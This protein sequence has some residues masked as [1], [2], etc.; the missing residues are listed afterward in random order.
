ME[1]GHI[2]D[3]PSISRPRK[4][5]ARTEG[6][7]VDVIARNANFE[8]EVTQKSTMNTV[9]SI[10]MATVVWGPDDRSILKM[11]LD[12][13]TIEGNQRGD[14]SKLTSVPLEKTQGTHGAR[15]GVS[16]VVVE[17]KLWVE[18]DT[19][20][21]SRRGTAELDVV[22]GVRV[23]VGRHR[24]VVGGNRAFCWVEEEARG[25]APADEGIKTRLENFTVR[26][27]AYPKE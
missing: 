27:R 23:Q 4:M 1:E 22:Y 8:G 12:Q 16:D 9:E 15:R 19:Q 5:E 26:R 11:R 14:M 18:D 24:A 7:V 13:C 10:N 2:R 21:A 17:R 3:Q 20:I 6:S 25:R